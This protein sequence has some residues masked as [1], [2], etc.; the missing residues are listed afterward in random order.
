MKLL[1]LTAA[2]AFVFTACEPAAN[3][4]NNSNMNS[5]A[6]MNANRAAAAAPSK[7]TLLSLERNAFEAWKNKDAKFWETYISDRFATVTPMGKVDKAAVL[8]HFASDD[9]DVKSYS[10]AD[11]QLKQLGSDAAIITY[12]ATADATCG[13]KK[14]PA[15]TWVATILVR[16]GE[17]WKAAFHGE[18]PIPDSNA[19]PS[20]PAPA[21]KPIERSV[22]NAN[23]N[24]NASPAAEPKSDGATDAMFT[25]EKKAWEAWKAKDAAT[26]NDWASNDLVAFTSNGRQDRAGA[27]KTWMEDGCQIN[28]VS[29]TDP[30]SISFGPDYGLLLFKASVDGKCGGSAVPTEYGATVYGK[31]AG[32]WKALFTMGTTAE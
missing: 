2:A 4:V 9:C 5:N 15:S 8:K 14:Q 13:G 12:K 32:A 19:Q 18:S 23:S 3:T 1:L 20:K 30:S 11:E 17:Q 16:D 24:A 22:A 31:E 21:R 29:L 7:E 25:L 28:T 26:I 6:N 10:L 27:V